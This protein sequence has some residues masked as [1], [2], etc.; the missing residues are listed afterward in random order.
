MAYLM[1]MITPPRWIQEPHEITCM[2]DI[3]AESLGDLCAEEN[4]ISTW[5]VGDKTEHE[6]KQAVLAL[7]SGFRALDEIKVVFLDDEEIRNAGLS[8]TSNAGVTKIK[9]YAGLHRDIDHLNAGKLVRLADIVLRQVWE[10][11][12]QTFYAED[13]A[14][15]MLQVMEQGKLR[16]E[17]L[18][19]NFRNGL[20]GK[21]KKLIN[22]KRVILEDIDPELQK[23]LQE[24]WEQNKKKTNCRYEMECPRYRR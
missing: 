21:V 11:Q 1:R 13:I 7:A 19:K 6:I 23:S 18:D 10:E 15:W 9:E 3:N 24:Q 12:T 2:E 8:I 16:F 4:A 22:K 20:A 5:C 14:L 17:S